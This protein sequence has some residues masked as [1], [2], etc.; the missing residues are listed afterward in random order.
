MSNDGASK[1]ITTNIFAGLPVVFITR[2][3][4]FYLRFNTQ[5]VRLLSLQSSYGMLTDGYFDDFAFQAYRIN[6][7]E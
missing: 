4:N 7:H 2:E 1:I 3:P 6:K 5:Y